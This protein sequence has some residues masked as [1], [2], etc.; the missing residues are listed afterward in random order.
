[1]KSVIL[2]LLL[3][4]ALAMAADDTKPKRPGKG[5]EKRPDPAEAF[6]KL[7]TNSDGNVSLEEFKA[8]PAG[9]RDAAKAE[10]VYKKM[11]KDS[12]GKLTVEEFK[13]ARSARKGG[14]KP[15]APKT[16]PEEPKKA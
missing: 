14:D 16:K 7:D 12:D 15:E 5:T 3:V 10:E 9:K 11:D 1:M 2:S 8:G 4:P 13:A 6:K